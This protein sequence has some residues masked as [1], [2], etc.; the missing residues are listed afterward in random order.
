MFFRKTVLRSTWSSLLPA[1]ARIAERFFI[2][3]SV[4]A[5]TSPSITCCVAGSIATCPETNT[6]PLARIAWEYGPI[7]L[8]ALEVEI[9]SRMALLISDCVISDCRLDDRKTKSE[10]KAGGKKT[11]A[12]DQQPATNDRSQTLCNLCTS[13]TPGIFLTP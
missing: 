5:A 6:K 2:T 9:T 10:M 8:G 12:N 3:R 7:A 1:A 4:C 11:F 13:C